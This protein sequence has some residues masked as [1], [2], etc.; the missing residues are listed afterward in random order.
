LTLRVAGGSGGAIP[1]PT[2]VTTFAALKE[3]V[4]SQMGDGAQRSENDTATGDG[5]TTTF[6]LKESKPSSLT[7]TLDGTPTTAF[8]YDDETGW[9]EFT[10]APGDGV[11]IVFTYVYH[12]FSDTQL[13]RAVNCAV[14]E[15]FG[16][17]YVEGVHDDIATTGDRE[18][19]LTDAAHVNLDPSARVYRVEISYDSGVNWKRLDAWRVDTRAT[20]KVLVFERAPADGYL[21][22]VSFHALPGQFT[23]DV[24]TLEATVGLPTRA[25]EPLIDY[26]CAELMKYRI[27]PNVRDDR[28]HNTQQEKRLKSYEL[29]NDAQFLRAQAQLKARRL[30]MD[31]L[32]TRVVL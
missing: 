17:F 7:I 23:S 26:A 15:L 18:Y 9:V 21:L 8:S 6:A 25:S 30:R 14:M 1:S 31:P 12:V 2:G 3:A 29:V 32:R 13:E 24:D 5:A 22:R 11:A 4:R 28:A 27:A 20:T 10:S 19:T 16:D